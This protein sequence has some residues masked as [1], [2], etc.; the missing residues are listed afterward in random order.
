MRVEILL[1]AETELLE[2]I[3]YYE[4]IEPG[5]GLSLK[6]EVRSSI[7]WIARNPFVP[8]LRSR[9]YHRVNLKVFPYYVAYAVHDDAL[10]ILAVVHAHR[11]PEYWIERKKG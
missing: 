8:R 10:W 4:G 9:G 1:E 7:A 11:R 5:L 3:D 2:S 6:D